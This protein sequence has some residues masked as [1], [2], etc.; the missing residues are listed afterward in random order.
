MF[1]PD[2]DEDYIYQNL[3]LSKLFRQFK[4]LK[5]MVIGDLMI[6]AYY[7]GKV[8]RIS[9]E[10]PVPV[11][12][13]ERKENRLGGAAN[14]ALNIK[15]LGAQVCLCGLRGNDP[16]GDLL[17]SML[18]EEDLKSEGLITDYERVSTVKTRIIGNNHQVLRIDSEQTEAVSDA[19]R[20]KLFAFIKSQM[21]E[22]DAVVFED[23]NKGVLDKALIAGVIELAKEHN[24]PTIVDPKKENFFAYKGVNLFKPNRKEVAEAL[25]KEYDLKDKSQLLQAASE[26]LEVLDCEQVMITLSE[27]GILIY[28]R[29][30]Y[31]HIP[32]HQRKIL[33]VSG[34]GDTVV[35]VASLCTALNL[36]MKVT[37][38]IS[39]L[40]GGLVCENLGVV[41]ID[42][43]ILLNESLQLK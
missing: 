35:A 3:S 23:Y 19:V 37:A 42:A 29:H 43:D 36:P 8:E 34:A 13:V 4:E 32:S 27:D 7:Y 2:L 31:Y 28:S 14:V 5:V 18:I 17:E 26:L 41:P 20:Q 33:D 40:A 1:I 9:P 25:K 30:Q 15:S 16:E 6:D 22:V 12:S 21:E 24:V 10:A 39:N 11:V 38:E